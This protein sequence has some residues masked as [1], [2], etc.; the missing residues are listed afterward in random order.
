MLFFAIIFFFRLLS[1]SQRR[2]SITEMKEK[3]D[4]IQIYRY[5]G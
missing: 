5:E 3:H 1:L 4:K 2:G